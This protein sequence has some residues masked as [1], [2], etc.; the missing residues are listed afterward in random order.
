MK[1]FNFFSN[2]IA[3][4]SAL[5]FGF[6]GCGGGGGGSSS[7]DNPSNNDTPSVI[8]KNISGTAV[9]GYISGATVCLDINSN[10]T[11]DSDEPSTITASD[12]T[13]SLDVEVTG[14]YPII[15]LG[16]TDT[17]T[18][19]TFEGILKEIVELEANTTTVSALITPLTT[20]ATEIYQEQKQ[21]N[22]STTP[23]QAKQTVAT[24]LGLNLED[25]TKDPM[26]DTNVFAKTQQIV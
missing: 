12:G 21:S 6:T 18:N 3:L 19:E 24:N 10:D 11:C 17:A 14:T 2:K 15:M 23:I 9:D 7:S 8:T 22:L 5:V 4:C 20:I 16:G 13:Y 26:N 1:R 25:I